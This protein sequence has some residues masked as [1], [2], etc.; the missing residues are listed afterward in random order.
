MARQIQRGRSPG[1]SDQ[2]QPTKQRLLRLIEAAA[3]IEEIKE[4]LRLM[5]NTQIKAAG[6]LRRGG[7]R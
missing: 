5:T 6:G 7:V 2:V 4:I 1:P 3:S